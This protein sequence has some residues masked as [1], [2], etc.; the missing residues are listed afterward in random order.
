MFESFRS[1]KEVIDQPLFLSLIEEDQELAEM[2]SRLEGTMGW[3]EIE[4]G[5]LASFMPDD[6]YKDALSTVVKKLDSLGHKY[7]ERAIALA[8]AEKL[9]VHNLGYT[10]FF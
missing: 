7:Q 1:R 10:E 5:T 3:E 4:D 9:D 2:V 6:N 8:V